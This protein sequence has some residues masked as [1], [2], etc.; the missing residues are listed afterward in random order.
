MNKENLYEKVASFI[1]A[2]G[3]T[4]V[5]TDEFRGKLTSFVKYEISITH[6]PFGDVNVV[7]KD[8]TVPTTVKKELLYCSQH[9]RF[10]TIVPLSKITLEIDTDDEY[11]TMSFYGD[12]EVPLCN[13]WK[14]D[15]SRVSDDR[16]ADLVE[17]FDSIS[18]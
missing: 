15:L 13:L 3:K 11:E 12:T 8:G 5:R 4:S 16:L 14:K 2:H 18:A 10:S 17:V 9:I 6:S 1:K 7:T